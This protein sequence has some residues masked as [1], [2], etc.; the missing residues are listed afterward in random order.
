MVFFSGGFTSY[1]Q[2]A[3]NILLVIVCASI[4]IF[5]C[6]CLLIKK[7]IIG[8]KSD[9]YK[10]ILY[11]FLGAP[12]F[13]I[14]VYF[15]ILHM[16]NINGISRASDYINQVTDIYAAESDRHQQVL[17]GELY[18]TFGDKV[19]N[20]AISPANENLV[21]LSSGKKIFFYDISQNK[22]EKI[23]YNGHNILNTVF[24]GNG[25]YIGIRDVGNFG[26][27]DVKKK[28][29]FSY[30]NLIFAWNTPEFICFSE[31]DSFLISMGYLHNIGYVSVAVNTDNGKVTIIPFGFERCT[32][33]FVTEEAA[34]EC[35]YINR[36]IAEFKAFFFGK[37][38]VFDCNK[39]RI[40]KE[41]SCPDLNKNNVLKQQK[42]NMKLLSFHFVSDDIA[43]CSYKNYILKI[44]TEN[45]GQYEYYEFPASVHFRGSLK[46]N[47][48][49]MAIVEGQEMKE[50]VC[51]VFDT[52]KMKPLSDRIII[53]KN[54]FS[55]K[56]YAIA[57]S[58]RFIVYI[59]DGKL[60]KRDIK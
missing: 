6:A 11:L 4:P 30:S 12:F 46:T 14:P 44:F 56:N 37:L 20:V 8:I 54:S 53:D 10:S 25:K 47:G 27:Y 33:A 45:P 34:N 52:I 5:L 49:G 18:D 31:N 7:G 13:L 1:L 22:F 32:D 39:N 21:L 3:N 29:F 43:I 50:H 38:I 24:S 17:A 57:P 35:P 59:R 19:T 58:G 48:V 2:N 41:L 55:R 60:F 28:V 9:F 36:D 40:V 26:Y 16:Y 23:P 42:S 15:L 51:Y